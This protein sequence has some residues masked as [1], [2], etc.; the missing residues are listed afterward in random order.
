LLISHFCLLD[1]LIEHLH[2]R[3]LHRTPTT[4]TLDN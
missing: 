4:Y 2:A 3:I 1:L